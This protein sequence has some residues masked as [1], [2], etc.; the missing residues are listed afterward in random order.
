MDRYFPIKIILTVSIFLFLE[1]IFA[2]RWTPEDD[3]NHIKTFDAVLKKTVTELSNISPIKKDNNEYFS[4]KQYDQIEGLYFRYTLCTRSL[5]D[6][7]NAYKDFSNRSKYTKNNVQ[8][9]ILGYCATLT[10]YKYSAELILNTSGKPLLIDKLNEEY[11][12][13]E[14]K[15]GGLDFIINNLTNP[16][17]INNLDIAHEFYQRQISD[18]NK[19][20]DTS[21]FDTIIIEL[22]K[23]TTELSS[24]YINH[25]KT[26]I[27]KYTILPLEAADIMQVTTIEETVN[28][29]IDAAGGQLKAIQE[30]LFTLTGDIRMPLVDGITFS[31][32]QKRSLRKSL[33]PGDII[34]TFSSGYL[35]NIFLPGYFKHVL[36]FTGTHDQK[37][38]KYIKGIRL[39]PEQQKL[40][41]TEHDIIEANSDG[42]TTS[43]LEN[44]L[45]GY[46]NRMIIFRPSLSDDDI[47]T[48][49]NNLHSYLG[50]AYDFDF[51]LENG[52]KQTCIE[53]IYRS[54]NGIGN[55]KLDLEEIFGTTTL[56]GDNLLEY[57]IK[58][59]KTK[60]IL[61]AVENE[62]KPGRAEFLTD[63]DAISYLKQ[64]APKEINTSN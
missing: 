19:L 59:D 35:S 1:A 23:T 55:I 16:D 12:R 18:N 50:V 61:L 6:I 7:V 39:K 60:L 41:S 11:P 9:F 25:K 29:M 17:Y 21:E 44:Y 2:Q 20:Y 5:L 54:Y 13:T 24:A 51:D 43:K 42:V 4:N 58:D 64:N 47:S 3:F 26:I 45:N 57:F 22:I 56:T 37:K 28:D 36:T 15:G 31:R 27:D 52:E 30:F 53:I 63:K 46:A 38:N 48:V 32:R 8:A 33:K 14:I 10:I 62:N 49:M 40:I 34:L